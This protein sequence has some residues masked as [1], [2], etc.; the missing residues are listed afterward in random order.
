MKLHDHGGRWAWAGGLLLVCLA[1]WAMGAMAAAPGAAAEPAPWGGATVLDTERSGQAL[2]AY[3]LRTL[4]P[5]SP[6]PSDGQCAALLDQHRNPGFEPRPENAGANQTNV[7]REGYRFPPGELEG[8]GARVTGDFTGTTDEIIQ[9]AA[10]KW[11]FD[12]DT[13]RAQAMQESHW[14][15]SHLGDCCPGQLTQPETGGCASIGFLQV[16]GADVPP[17]NAH[18]YPYA[19]ISTAFNVDYALAVRRAC[20]EGRLTWLNSPNVQIENGRPYAGATSGGASASGSRAA[21][22]TRSR[23]SICTSSR[24]WVKACCST[25]SARPGCGSPTRGANA[26][27][28]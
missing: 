22:T 1:A 19:L 3:P 28:A 8:S 24:I 10:C 18:T 15:Q 9:W 2:P 25:T 17:T 6:L 7:F 27:L 26:V 12:A 14:L 20:F 5:G 23:R 13:V 16:K 4:P 21:G 11:G